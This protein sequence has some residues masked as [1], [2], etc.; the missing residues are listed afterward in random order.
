M[1]YRSPVTNLPNFHFVSIHPLLAVL[2]QQLTQLRSFK[3]IIKGNRFSPSHAIRCCACVCK[4]VISSNKL[5]WDLGQERER[6]QLNLLCSVLQCHAVG[7]FTL[8]ASEMVLLPRRHP[9]WSDLFACHT[10]GGYFWIHPQLVVFAV[11]SAPRQPSQF[12]MILKPTGSRTWQT[13][14]TRRQ[15]VC[16]LLWIQ[17]V[18]RRAQ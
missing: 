9:S 3:T 16:L 17:T 15:C 14:G 8:D 6:R 11:L 10:A 5:I 7:K 4:C 2:S 13:S 1:A 18:N 12:W